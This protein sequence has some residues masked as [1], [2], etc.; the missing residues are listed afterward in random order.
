ML[1]KVYF[2]KQNTTLEYFF[3]CYRI[4][5]LKTQYHDAFHIYLMLYH[6]AEF[7]YVLMQIAF[8]YSVL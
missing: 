3:S 2:L 6:V 7:M 1:N 8:P 5:I 4:T